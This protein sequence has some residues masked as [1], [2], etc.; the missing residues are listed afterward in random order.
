MKKVK[1]LILLL[2]ASLFAGVLC[3]CKPKS[4]G[5]D[6]DETAQEQQQEQDGGNEDA[7]TDTDTDSD[8]DTDSDTDND[9]DDDSDPQPQPQPQPAEK[10]AVTYSFGKCGEENYAG[11]DVLPTSST[12]EEKATFVLAKAPAWAWYEFEGWNDGEKTYAAGATYT[13]PAHAVTLTAHWSARRVKDTSVSL[14]AW[15]ENSTEGGYTLRKGESITAIADLSYKDTGDGAYGVLAKIFPNAVI[16]N[17]SFYQARCDMI[18]K[19]TGWSWNENNDGFNVSDGGWNEDSYRQTT[20]GHTEIT[21]ALSASGVLTYRFRYQEKDGA[22]SHDRLF[23]DQAT[24]NSAHVLFGI[25]HASAENVSLEYPLSHAAKLTFNVG[26]DCFVRNIVKGDSYTFESDPSVTGTLFLG[27]QTAGDDVKYKAGSVY[28]VQGDVTF[29]ALLSV[30]AKVTVDKDGGTGTVYAPKAEYDEETGKYSIAQL[31]TASTTFKKTGFALKGWEIAVGGEPFTPEG[32]PF[33]VEEGAEVVFKAVWATPY[34]VTYSLGD[35][36]G[37][38]YGGSTK[39][40]TEA[41]KAETVQFTLAKAPEWAGYTFLGWSDGENTYQAGATYTMPAQNVTLTA[42]WEKLPHYA[43]SFVGGTC[44]NTA[45]DGQNLIDTQEDQYEGAVFPLARKLEWAGYEFLGWCDGEEIYP[46][47]YRYTM[48]AH[49]VTFTAQWKKLPTH[50]VTYDKGE[51][52]EDEVLNM[53]KSTTYYEGEIVMTVPIRVGYTFKGWQYGEHTYRP[54][55]AIDL[56]EDDVTFTATWEELPDE[57]KVFA[58]LSGVWKY[59][60]ENGEVNLQIGG[61][62]GAWDAYKAFGSYKVGE[63]EIVSVSD[64]K[65]VFIIHADRPTGS[66]TNNIRC[67]Y[68]VATDTISASDYGT[69]TRKTAKPSLPA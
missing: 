59:D 46:A 13:M 38:K 11:S 10:Y 52:G 62:E 23:T 24:M 42:Q 9:S 31:P 34:T 56:T 1:W 4:E 14:P 16:D 57:N 5:A 54:G 61:M 65:I 36:E 45:Y 58:L 20:A 29:T 55:D 6:K 66:G 68:D 17:N 18:V 49:A 53:P 15:V 22:Y 43:V 69:Y 27:W 3:A 63:I 67:T 39:K 41:A 50:T 2:A 19:R 64:T 28:S 12:K 33:Y 26:E 21:V 60:D 37:T 8:P 7:D 35:Y 32:Y 47:T 44:E 30:K 40:P 25:D 51:V 48:P